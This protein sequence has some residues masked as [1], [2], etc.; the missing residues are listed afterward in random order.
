MYWIFLFFS[1]FVNTSTE[2][3]WRYMLC[4]FTVFPNISW[5]YKL[6]HFH[7]FDLLQK[8]GLSYLDLFWQK[9]ESGLEPRPVCIISSS[10]N[11]LIFYFFYCLKFSFYSNCYVSIYSFELIFQQ[12]NFY[13]FISFLHK[14]FPIISIVV[15]PCSFYY[16]CFCYLV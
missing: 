13:T 5:K 4:T 6:Q 8:L 7:K 16:D 3:K 10:F 1:I 14:V 15:T 11:F 9:L 12:L 2:K